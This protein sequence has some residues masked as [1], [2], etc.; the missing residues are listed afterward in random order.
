MVTEC[1]LNGFKLPDA[2]VTFHSFKTSTKEDQL[3]HITSSKIDLLPE[4]STLVSKESPKLFQL[5]KD[6][7]VFFARDVEVCLVE[8]KSDSLFIVCKILS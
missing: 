1:I 7:V 4:L 8:L 5:K 2:T 6:H 3:I